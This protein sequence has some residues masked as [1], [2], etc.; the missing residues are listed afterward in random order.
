MIPPCTTRKGVLGKG[1]ASREAAWLARVLLPVLVHP[2]KPVVAAS[3][4]SCS[5]WCPRLGGHPALEGG[6]AGRR[7]G[8]RVVLYMVVSERR[9]GLKSARVHVR[10]ASARLALTSGSCCVIDR[11]ACRYAIASRQVSTPCSARCAGV[12]RIEAQV[13]PALAHRPQTSSG[14]RGPNATYSSSRRL[15]CRATVPP[16][17]PPLYIPLLP[18]PCPLHS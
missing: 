12:Q 1:S 9:G 14:V 5:C 6:Q 7:V 3:P 11:W 4:W 15:S 17:M 10:L 18:V 8:R 16:A 13:A 2:G